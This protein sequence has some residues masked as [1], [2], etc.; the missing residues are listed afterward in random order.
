M[1]LFVSKTLEAHLEGFFS[2]GRLDGNDSNKAYLSFWPPFTS[3]LK[4][5]D[6]EYL[7]QMYSVERLNTHK[8][9]APASEEFGDAVEVGGQI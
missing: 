5:L 9:Q 4:H 6:Q 2:F 1:S 8:F 3:T 7:E